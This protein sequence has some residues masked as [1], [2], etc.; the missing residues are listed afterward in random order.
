M[1]I[2]EALT[3]HA[4]YW[5]RQTNTF[6]KLNSE[7]KSDLIE[8]SKRENVLKQKLLTTKA[9]EQAH[10]S[11]LTAL[12]DQLV[13]LELSHPESSDPN[14]PYPRAPTPCVLRSTIGMG[15]VLKEKEMEVTTERPLP[16]GLSGLSGLLQYGY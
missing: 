4:K 1:K 6:F 2:I 15:K 12:K 13:F 5:H 3:P 8:S 7:L 10:R 16:S 14:D 9:Q 11:H